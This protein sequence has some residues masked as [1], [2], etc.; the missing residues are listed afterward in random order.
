MEYVVIRE[1][2]DKD[3]K[4]HYLVGE[5]YPHKGFATKERAEELSTDKNRRGKALIEAKKPEKK[6]EKVEKEAPVE[7]AEKSETVA[8]KKGSKK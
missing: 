1:F 7:T 8:K 3:T 4:E 6:A 5:R 2:T